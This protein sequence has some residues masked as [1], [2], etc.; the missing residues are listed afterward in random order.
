MGILPTID[1]FNIDS[2]ILPNMFRD[3]ASILMEAKAKRKP[4]STTAVVGRGHV[5]VHQSIEK[6]N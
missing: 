4:N 3:R 2:K 1:S 5:S 6:E